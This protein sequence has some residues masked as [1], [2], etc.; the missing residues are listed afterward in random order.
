MFFFFFQAEDGIRD[1]HVT[2]VQTCALPIWSIATTLMPSRHDS[3]RCSSQLWIPVLPR[4]STTPRTCPVRASTNVD[5]HGSIR[6]HERVWGSRKNRA[7]AKRRS[8][9]RRAAKERQ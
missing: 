3:E 1:G 8:E 9:E 6:R 2:G 7:R 4:P 5:I